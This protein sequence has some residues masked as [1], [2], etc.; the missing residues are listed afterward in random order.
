M[1][2]LLKICWVDESRQKIADS[3]R[4]LLSC[5]A[6]FYFSSLFILYTTDT[7]NMLRADL[8]FFFNHVFSFGNLP[9]IKTIVTLIMST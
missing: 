4:S 3:M 2:S 7:V 1:E 6:I 8:L 9:F 5:S